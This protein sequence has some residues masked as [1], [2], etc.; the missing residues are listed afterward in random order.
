MNRCKKIRFPKFLSKAKVKHQLELVYLLSVFIP[1]LLLGAFLMKNSSEL[2]TSYYQDMLE[3]DNLRVK[4][5]ISEITAQVTD[6][7]EELAF[8]EAVVPL[9]K[10][11]RDWAEGK[12]SPN[13]AV[14]SISSYIYTN[15][16]IADISIITDN[17][18]AEGYTHFS[19]AT[20]EDKITNWYQR[21]K[22]E[23]GIFWELLSK[24]NRK[25]AVDWN[26]S[27]IRQVSLGDSSYTAVLIIKISDTYLQTH[28]I[29][30]E[31]TT[32]L[33]TDRGRFFIVFPEKNMVR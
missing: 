2:L 4:N 12:I 6:I 24:P 14:A 16:Q 7:S 3:A 18:N 25:G 15:S 32:E 28:I 22:Q 30:P 8:A 10:H 26:L 21:A 11:E 33:V 9:L 1:I 20:E 13:V 19:V 31:Y 23:A 29:S 5:V 17:P 27:L